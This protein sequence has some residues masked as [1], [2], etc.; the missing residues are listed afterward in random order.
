MSDISSMLGDSV[1]R[2]FR[3]NVDREFLQEQEKTGWAAQL[4]E[5]TEAYV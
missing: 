3:D 5:L 1:T 2:L 4:W